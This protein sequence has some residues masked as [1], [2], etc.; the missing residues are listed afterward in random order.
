MVNWNEAHLLDKTLGFGPEGIFQLLLA[1]QRV[2][3]WNFQLAYSKSLTLRLSLFPSVLSIKL[4]RNRC[5]QNYSSVIAIVCVWS[6]WALSNPL[7]EL[8][9]KRAG[10]YTR[11]MSHSLDSSSN[12]RARLTQWDGPFEQK[13]SL[14]VISASASSYPFPSLHIY[15][16]ESLSSFRDSQDL[17]LQT[18]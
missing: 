13:P 9:S 3:V 12:K 18:G 6:E 11:R 16:V 17:E 8:S 1:T 4:T 14:S 10:P 15:R 2:F 7:D 5:G